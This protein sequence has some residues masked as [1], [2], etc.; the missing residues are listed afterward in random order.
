MLMEQRYTPDLTTVRRVREDIAA[1]LRMLPMSEQRINDLLLA[2]SEAFTNIVRHSAPSPTFVSLSLS[3]QDANIRFVLEDDG[4]FFDGFDARLA[5]AVDPATSPLT[6]GGMGIGLIAQLVGGIDYRR[7]GATNRLSFAE[8]VAVSRRPAIMLIDDD[9]VIR[10]LARSYL[11]TD[12]DVREYGDAE[13]ALKSIAGDPPDLI[14]S[15]IAMPEMDGLE[16]R[17][18]L[19]RDGKTALIPFIFLTGLECENVEER[20]SALDIDDFLEKPVSRKRLVN[21]VERVLRRSRQLRKAL[22]SSIDRRITESLRSDLPS[23]ASGWWISQLAQPASPGGGDMVLHR[24]DNNWTSLV[25][26]DVMGHGVPAKIFAFAYAGYVQSL[27][28][29]DSLATKPEALI[30]E[31]SVRIANDGRFDE[32]IVTCAAACLHRDGRAVLAVGGHPRPLLHR[33]GQPWRPIPLVG[34]IPGISNTPPTPKT[35][36]M[37][38]GDALLLVS[39]GL[40]EALSRGHPEAALIE[41]LNQLGEVTPDLLLHLRTATGHAED[42]RTALLLRFSG[43]DQG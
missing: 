20:A 40:G 42:D 26:L 22:Q 31:L 5:N 9:A 1:T 43:T 39:D 2:T 35:V 8:P 17:A 28:A 24:I 16:L 6:E 13:D 19:Q 7:I 11:Q 36:A 34:A 4:G 33:P 10:T 14:V 23:R 38:P 15:D 21:T 3:H 37:E 32:T 25:L 27:L 12:Y 30:N 41:S 29:E 18:R